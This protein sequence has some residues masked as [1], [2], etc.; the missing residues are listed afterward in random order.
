[1]SLTYFGSVEN[2]SLKI[3]NRNSLILDLKSLEGKDVEIKI[4]RKKK[5][6][7]L[8]QNSYYWGCVIPIVKQGLIDNGFDRS[9]IN[10]TSVVHEFLKSMFCP[11]VEVVNEETGE[12]LT[13][14]PTTTNVSTV[15]MMEYFADI[16]Q[17]ASE[18]LQLIIP[19]PGE[20][21]MMSFD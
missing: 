7:S 16:Q 6:R 2:G 19:N 14:P 21:M 9:I 1:M 18:K 10:S 4:S 5:T 12:I 15:Q 17:W 3:R 13:L 8:N 11:K 20:E